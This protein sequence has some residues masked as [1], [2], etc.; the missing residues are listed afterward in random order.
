[1][2]SDSVLH[3]RPAALGTPVL[4]KSFVRT[5][6]MERKEVFMTKIVATDNKGRSAFTEPA[7]DPPASTF[8]MC[9]R[10]R[11]KDQGEEKAASDDVEAV[12]SIEELWQET[13][14]E[15]R[16][17]PAAAASAT[18]SGQHCAYTSSGEPDFG[19]P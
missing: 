10:E 18:G 2:L 19:R 12:A 15:T 17:F 11:A 5:L 3:L 4:S 16:T 1:V 13:I 9:L 7:Y 8:H 6:E 14:V